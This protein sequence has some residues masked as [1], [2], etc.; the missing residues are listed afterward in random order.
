MEIKQILV[1]S[2]YENTLLRKRVKA[3]FSKKYRGWSNDFDKKF[4]NH[5]E[6]FSVYDSSNEKRLLACCRVTYKKQNKYLPIE[7]SQY[8]RFMPNEAKVCEINNFL[9]RSDEEAIKMLSLVM[10]HLIK[11]G[12]KYVYCVVDE[13]DKKALS[14][15][16]N[17]FGFKPVDK[18][19]KFESVVHKLTNKMVKWD[20]LVQDEETRLML[21][22]PTSVS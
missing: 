5:S 13:V 21:F 16:T 22:N 20:I 8:N 7:L 12:I 3:R 14:F 1:T 6:W 11:I 19:I 10:S 9:R 4:D 17:N 18:S 2:E 15:N